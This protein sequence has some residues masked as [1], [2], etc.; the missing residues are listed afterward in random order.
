MYLERER[1]REVRVL[2][3]ED[4]EMSGPQKT[5]LATQLT[6]ILVMCNLAASFPSARNNKIM[7]SL[8]LSVLV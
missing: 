1:E 5:A 8:S 3:S 7:P 2:K 6:I 4:K